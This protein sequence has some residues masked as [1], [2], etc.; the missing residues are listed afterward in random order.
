M[1][2]P[3]VVNIPNQRKIHTAV[4]TN[5]GAQRAWRAPNHLRPAG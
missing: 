1:P 4:V 2:I 5:V 3:Y